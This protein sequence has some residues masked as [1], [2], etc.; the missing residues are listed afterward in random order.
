[1]TTITQPP[2][3]AVLVDLTRCIGCRSCQVACKSWNE[4]SVKK[5]V[6]QGVYTNP[7]KLNSDTYTR[8]EF[9]EGASG[10]AP[11]WHFIKDQCMH[12]DDPACVS[13]CP[14]G[15]FKKLPNGPVNYDYDK[16]IGC[17]YCMIACPFQVPKYEWEKRIFP[18][19]RKCTFC[20]D[21][22]ADNLTPACI[23]ICPTKT[24]FFGN[25]EEVLAEA[26]K[27]LAEH[28]GKYVNYVYGEK[29]AGGTSWMYI[30]AVPFEQ[31]GFN[32]N[33]PAKKLPENTWAMLREIPF[34]VV[35]FVTALSLIAVFRNRGSNPD[36]ESTHKEEN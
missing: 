11:A 19:V 21:R 15:A 28:P 30:A 22:Q 25:K 3:K 5:T 17:R 6:N 23:K 18:W 7:P 24:M 8:I 35:G 27:R 16:C 29:E 33:I 12:C 20:S 26:K 9:L 34:K 2:Q 10:Q 4:R 32:M 1:M 13:A 36:A 14:V 31:L